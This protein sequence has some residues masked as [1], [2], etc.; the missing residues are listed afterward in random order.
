MRQDLDKLKIL[1]IR[2]GISMPAAFT[3]AV[4]AW[5][6]SLSVPNTKTSA[7]RRKQATAGQEAER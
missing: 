6:K 4:E 1:S 7:Q 3:L 2:K 5:E